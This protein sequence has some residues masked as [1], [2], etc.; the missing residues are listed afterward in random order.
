MG[1]V[2]IGKVYTAELKNVL[3]HN[4]IGFV[5]TCLKGHKLIG[6]A[7]VKMLVLRCYRGLLHSTLNVISKI[8]QILENGP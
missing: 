5:S 8:V 1:V 7:P 2:G 4:Q 6:F 3:P